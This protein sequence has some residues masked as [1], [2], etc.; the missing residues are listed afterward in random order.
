MGGNWVTSHTFCKKIGAIENVLTIRNTYTTA[1]DCSG[2]NYWSGKM[3]FGV[4]PNTYI[5]YGRK[6]DNFS[7][8]LQENRFKNKRSNN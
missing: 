2:N 8:F 7:Y 5:M 4:E 1:A 6:L 3:F